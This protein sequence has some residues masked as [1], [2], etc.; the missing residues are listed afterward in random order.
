MSI[1][2]INGLMIFSNISSFLQLKLIDTI[3]PADNEKLCCTSK[4]QLGELNAPTG[5]QLRSG[6]FAVLRLIDN[7]CPDPPIRHIYA[8]SS[9][10]KGLD[11]YTAVDAR[12][13]AVQR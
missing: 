4:V 7:P 1:F 10:S 6:Q 11:L 12:S 2:G 9:S 5:Q 13:K 8:E 3:H